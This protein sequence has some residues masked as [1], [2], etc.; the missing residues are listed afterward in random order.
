MISFDNMQYFYHLTSFQCAQSIQKYGFKRGLVGM[1]GPGIYFAIFPEDTIKKAQSTIKDTIIE[2]IN[3]RGYEIDE[4]DF[5]FFSDGKK[6]IRVCINQGYDIK[7]CFNKIPKC[8]NGSNHEYPHSF[9]CLH[10]ISK[11]PKW[12]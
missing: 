12:T 11:M 4:T 2:F 8:Q 5:Y 6:S 3:Y 7:L 10:W 9:Y 1:L